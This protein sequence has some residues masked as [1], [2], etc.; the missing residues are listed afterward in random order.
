MLEKRLSQS[1]KRNR[2]EH[3]NKV[4]EVSSGKGR[5]PRRQDRLRLNNSGANNNR[6]C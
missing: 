2:L 4:R 6:K 5:R 1:A 3:D